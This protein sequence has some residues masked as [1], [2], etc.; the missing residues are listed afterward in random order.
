MF[1]KPIYVGLT[2]PDVTKILMYDFHYGYMRKKYHNN[3]KLWYTDTDSL[4]YELKC[5]DIYTDMK[6]DMKNIIQQFDKSDTSDYSRDNV[7]GMP[8]KKQESYRPHER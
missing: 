4:I 6:E 1:N 5:Q 7:F 8:Q 3:C 2:V